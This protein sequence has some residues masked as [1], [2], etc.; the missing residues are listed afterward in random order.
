MTESFD[1]D[2]CVYLEYSLGVTFQKSEDERI[3]KLWCDGVAMPSSN[4]LEKKFISDNR[5][6]I[7]RAWIGVDGQSEFEMTI[8]LGKS[9]LQRFAQGK[10]LKDCISTVNN[11]DWII[12]N[13]EKKKIELRLL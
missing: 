7:T 2:F 6:L 9:S 1:E 12:I 8:K 5:K 4:Q 11:F 10:S 3:K 13:L